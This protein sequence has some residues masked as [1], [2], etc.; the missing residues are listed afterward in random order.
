MAREAVA[1]LAMQTS[2][3]KWIPLR[4]AK[5]NFLLHTR[6]TSICT[7]VSFECQVWEEPGKPSLSFSDCPS[8]CLRLNHCRF[9]PFVRIVAQTVKNLPATQETWV[10][11]LGQGK[12]LWRRKRQPT[13]VF[14]PGESH[15]Q[16]SLIGCRPWG[17]TESDTTEVTW[18]HALLNRTKD[19]PCPKEVHYLM[20]PLG[21]HW[22]LLWIFCKSKKN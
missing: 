21:S 19:T 17:C 1:S 6:H 11:S 15:G 9:F 18:Q 16:R 4:P 12:I 20:M 13:P 14:L 2:L 8:E 10:R 22:F 3:D 7:E 5:A